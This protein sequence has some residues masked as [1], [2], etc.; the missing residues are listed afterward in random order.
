MTARWQ[1]RAVALG[2]VTVLPYA[3]FLIRS[4][5]PAARPEVVATLALMIGWTALAAAM[6]RGKR[7]FL[8]A[9]AL[10]GAA[11]ATGPFYR[12]L[13]L[14]AGAWP[15]FWC[16]FLAALAL[17]M[18][19]AGRLSAIVTAAAVSM[20]AAQVA[21]E[22]VRAAPAGAARTIAAPAHHFLY[23][24]L[25]EHSGAA[26]FP[27]EIA[28]CRPAR[29]RLA[30][31]YLRHGFRVFP[32]AYSNYPATVDSIPSILNRRLA[33]RRYEFL[34]GGRADD[35]GIYHVEA[36]AFFERFQ[37][38]GY[39]IHV[40]QFRGIAFEGAGDAAV[41]E[42]SDSLAPLAGMDYPWWDKARLLVG[43]Y[44]ATDEV[45]RAWKGLLPFRCADRPMLPI[46]VADW[47][48]AHLLADI[49][50]AQRP[51]LFFAH[52]LLPHGPYLYREDGSLRPLKEWSRDELYNR[53]PDQE[54]RDRYR[55]YAAQ[56]LFVGGQVDWLLEQLNRRGLLD[57][58]TI[59][60]HSDHASRIRR[61][62]PEAPV[63]KTVD[64]FD[65][66]APPGE[67]DLLDRFSIL[68][69]FRPPGAAE[70]A[71]DERRRSVLQLIS[72][73]VYGEPAAAA[74]SP[75]IL[76]DENQAQRRVYF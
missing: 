2:C 61:I 36:G 16:I 17:G 8:A 44:Q 31:I 28:E 4:R 22:A 6:L 15:L 26:G 48:P 67:R 38:Q 9:W 43:R 10:G 74:D 72:E 33:G 45:F 3:G 76:F 46:S 11:V 25:D 24:I 65:Y 41:R 14:R 34:R 50:S 7:L 1:E 66:T 68:F 5:Y 30:S 39:G 70:G 69:A 19:L 59:V 23:L 20:L 54:Y 32:Q 42:Y 29:E 47:W 27:E 53:V 58:L 57:Q 13:H 62:R 64:R 12:L 40:T 49:A 63:S 60:V 71:L 35:Y 52:I 21:V 55:R 56:A 73:T 75:M 51:T 18:L 37:R